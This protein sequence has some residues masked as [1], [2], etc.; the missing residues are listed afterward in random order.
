MGQV[1]HLPGARYVGGLQI[2]QQPETVEVPLDII[3]GR[4]SFLKRQLSGEL[5]LSRRLEP[6]RDGHDPDLRA[7]RVKIS[8]ETLEV[9]AHEHHVALEAFLGEWRR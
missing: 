2:Q 5:R 9:P 7:F 3:V 4:I 8:A 6:A 1:G